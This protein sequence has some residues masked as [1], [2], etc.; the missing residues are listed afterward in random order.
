MFAKNHAGKEEIRTRYLFGYRALTSVWFKFLILLL[1]SKYNK[2]V[3]AY[4]VIIYKM[5]TRELKEEVMWNMFIQLLHH[6]KHDPLDE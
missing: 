1:R 6:F 2:L 3:F 4:G 5:C